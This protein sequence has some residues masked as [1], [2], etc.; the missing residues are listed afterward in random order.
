[1]PKWWNFAKSGHCGDLLQKILWA[2]SNLTPKLPIF[3]FHQLQILPSYT[4]NVGPISGSTSKIGN[5]KRFSCIGPKDT[6][7]SKNCSYFCC[8]WAEKASG[9]IFSVVSSVTRWLPNRFFK[10]L[11]Q[12]I[13]AQQLSSEYCQNNPCLQKNEFWQWKAIHVGES[14]PF[15]IYSRWCALDLKRGPPDGRHRQ[16]HWAIVAP[17]QCPIFF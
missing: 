1:M 7:K 12:W 5:K 13:F 2:D 9:R 8:Y 10:H 15:E 16:I 11:Q 4:H 14:L 17:N 6:F 3:Y